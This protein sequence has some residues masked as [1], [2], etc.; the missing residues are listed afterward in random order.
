MQLTE[1]LRACR[2][3]RP[4]RVQSTPRSSAGAGP[5]GGA[6]GQAAPGGAMAAG[7]REGLG[8]EQEC[9]A[10]RGHG[11][12]R[13]GEDQGTTQWWGK[14]PDSRG[15]EREEKQ[16]RRGQGEG[17]ALASGRRRC[18]SATP[19]QRSWRRSP[20]PR[21]DPGRLTASTGSR[22]RPRPSGRSRR[23]RP[24]TWRGLCGASCQGRQASQRGKTRRARRPSRG[25]RGPC[26]RLGGQRPYRSSGR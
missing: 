24:G 15:G 19:R 8:W 9:R 7:N 10:P 17:R 13:Q 26:P 20:R 22:G 18:P 2:G 25:C 16:T 11:D 21:R 5:R 4:S 6:T 12:V 1:C 3:R 14:R 23:R